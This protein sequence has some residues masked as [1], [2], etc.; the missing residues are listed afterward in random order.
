[1]K[2][3]AKGAALMAGVDSEVIMNNGLYEILTNETGAKTLQKNIEIIGPIKYTEEEIK[4]ANHIMKA[5]GSESKGINGSIH[6]IKKKLKDLAGGSTD[7]GDVSYIVPEISLSATTAPAGKP[8]HSWV[9]VSC[10][11]MSIG[12]KGMLFASKSLGTTMV[13]LFEDKAL[14]IKIR[15]E[16]IQKKGKEVWKAMIPDGPAPIPNLN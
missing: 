10:G 4:F 1:M 3:I 5:Y 9:V 16:F 13:D 6:P 2:S 7:V 12:H 14:I 11:G 8:W 15:E